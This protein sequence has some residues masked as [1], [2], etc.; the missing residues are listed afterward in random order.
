MPRLLEI[1]SLVKL[2]VHCIKKAVDN[3]KLVSCPSAIR[4]LNDNSNTSFQQLRKFI[5]EAEIFF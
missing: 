1:E 4:Y 2:C 3:I 5:A